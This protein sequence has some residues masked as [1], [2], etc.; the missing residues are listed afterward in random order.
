MP[1]TNRAILNPQTADK[2]HNEGYRTASLTN[3]FD[4]NYQHAIQTNLLKGSNH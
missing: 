1:K 4:Q 3:N 2:Y